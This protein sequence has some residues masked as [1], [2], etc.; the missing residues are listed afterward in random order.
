MAY[1]FLGPITGAVY[2]AVL[3]TVESKMKPE[4]EALKLDKIDNDNDD[5]D[6]EGES[7]PV[8]S[9]SEVLNNLDETIDLAARAL[10]DCC[11]FR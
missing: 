1:R 10:N 4:A 8:A 2:R 7:S 3:K 6:G 5:S 9:D 11:S